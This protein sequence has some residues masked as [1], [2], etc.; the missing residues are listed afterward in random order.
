M[1]F[2]SVAAEP[3][4]YLGEWFNRIIGAFILFTGLIFISIIQKQLSEMER[5]VV[6]IFQIHLKMGIIGLEVEIVQIIGNMVVV[7][8]Q[9]AQDPNQV[10]QMILGVISFIWKLQVDLVMVILIQDH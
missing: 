1:G 6:I 10:I 7:H 5:Q 9:V 2:S 8:L 4:P 3:E